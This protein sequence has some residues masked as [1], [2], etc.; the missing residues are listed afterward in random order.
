MVGA[1]GTYGGPRIVIFGIGQQNAASTFFPAN[2]LTIVGL[3][4]GE[5]LE[6][7]VRLIAAKV[8]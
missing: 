2:Q 1:E 6:S 8:V 3:L 5:G 7:R 4:A